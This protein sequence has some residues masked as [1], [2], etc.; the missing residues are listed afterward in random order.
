MSG[1]KRLVN[2]S[3]ETEQTTFKGTARK[4]A[5]VRG[6]PSL[7]HLLHVHLVSILLFH[8]CNEI[9]N[10]VGNRVPIITVDVG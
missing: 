2:L 1:T 10:H 9:E 4:R 7:S 8:Y 6:W 5:T 3:V